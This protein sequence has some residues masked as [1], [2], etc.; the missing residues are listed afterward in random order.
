MVWG[1]EIEMVLVVLRV[2][3]GGRVDKYRIFRYV[4]IIIGVC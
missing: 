2:G 3:N 1:L 4:K